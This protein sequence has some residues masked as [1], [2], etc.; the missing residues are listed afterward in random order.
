[1]SLQLKNPNAGFPPGGFPFQDPKTGMIFNGYEGN[2]EMIAV[3]VSAHRQANQKLYPEGGGDVGGIVQE[4]FSQKNA[5]M[6]WLFSGGPDDPGMPP[7]AQVSA[8]AGGPGGSCVCGATETDPIYCPTCGGQRITGYK[9]RACGAE[10][11]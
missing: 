9:C 10:R 6:P 1:M 4:I 7:T 11:Q 5:Q 8:S 2:A 3:K